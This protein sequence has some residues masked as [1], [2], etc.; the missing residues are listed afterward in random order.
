NIRT[1]SMHRESILNVA[2]RMQ[3]ALDPLQAY[4]AGLLNNT[5][6]TIDFT[7]ITSIENAKKILKPKVANL[8]LGYQTDHQKQ[9]DLRDYNLINNVQNFLRKPEDVKTLLDKGS[10][11]NIMAKDL[12]ETL[13]RRMYIQSNFKTS[14]TEW[15]EKAGDLLFDQVPSFQD[16]ISINDANRPKDEQ[17]KEDFEQN[18]SSIQNELEEKNNMAGTM[19]DFNDVADKEAWISN[20]LDLIPFLSPQQLMYTK[21]AQPMG[22]KNEPKPEDKGQQQEDVANQVKA[23][24]QDL[25]N[26]K[27]KASARNVGNV[28]ISSTKQNQQIFQNALTQKNESISDVANELL[29]FLR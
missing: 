15:D 27:K 21:Y 19:P 3:E 13:S 23:D 16:F 26:K 2:I 5:D 4:E 17:D 1:N 14:L 12:F 7:D 18:I 22:I 11:N 29:D 10:I 9:L 6:V 28:N 25:K 20:H 8:E 24:T